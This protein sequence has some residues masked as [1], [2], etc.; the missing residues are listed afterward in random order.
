MET[1]KKQL[2]RTVLG[3]AVPLALQGMLGY[4]VN[5]VDTVMVGKLGTAALAGVSQ[6]NQIFFIVALTIPGIAAGASVLVSQAWGKGD[7]ERI[8]KVLAYTYRVAMVFIL[9]LMAVVIFFP[10]GVM[11]IYTPDAEAI[12]LGSKYLKIVVWSYLFYT[13]SNITTG[14]LRS[15]RSVNIC[16]Y[17]AIVSLIINVS[18]NYLLIEGHFGCPALG[19]EG[20]AIATLLA[21]MGEFLIILYY[22][23]WKED[24]IKIR[25]HKMRHLDKSICKIFFMTSIPVICNEMF[26]ALGV[27]AQAVV[28]G[29]L[30]NDIVSANSVGGSVTQLTT[31]ICQGIAAAACVIIGNTIGEER[32][33]AIKPL[34]R[35]FQILSVVMGL[36]SSG[37]VFLL[38]PFV[39]QIYHIQGVT[40]EYCRQLLIINMVILPFQQLQ[41]TNMMG[42]LRGG[43]DV[44]FQMANDLIFLWGFTVPLGFLTAFLFHAP[45]AVVYSC[46][47][48]DQVIKVF[49]S[50]WR[51]RKGNWVHNMNHL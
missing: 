15:V 25:I 41:S 26:W 12:D 47:K 28:L 38:I 14:V 42:L 17:S 8:H 9:L 51:I 20:A 16:L 44:K 45:V 7:V 43:G 13:I 50:E 2:S 36:I 23:Y 40:M 33:E 18:G 1:D 29:R 22:T 27:S 3:I 10:K 4:L 30:G 21:R 19:V 32:Y 6:A 46:L 31:V 34:K 37:L 39:P 5:L 24:K 11:K 35:Y 48:C 49:T